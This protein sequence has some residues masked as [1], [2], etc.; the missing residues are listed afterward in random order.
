MDNEVR[1]VKI[2]VRAESGANG[3]T[4][5]AFLPFNS[6]SQL[7]NEFGR[8]FIEQISPGA[9]KFPTDVR[10]LINHQ[11]YPV[12][13]RMSKKTLQIEQRA[14]GVAIKVDLPDT[15]A[16]NDLYTSV[17]RGDI[18]GISFNFAVNTN[19]DT[20]DH[21]Q[22]PP[23]RTLTDI[24][25]TEFSFVGEPAYQ[26]TKVAARSMKQ[27]DE[28]E[29]AA[30]KKKTDDEAAKLASDEAAIRAQAILYAELWKRRIEIDEQACA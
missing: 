15:A 26:D 20:W 19:G 7:I 13:G 16:A 27:H 28:A 18:G 6:R 8:S 22:N 23:L 29:S 5:S 9:F 4:L 1:S 21:Q 3:K 10:A 2:D 17:Q 24:S 11:G 14:D 30:A 12:L 25:S